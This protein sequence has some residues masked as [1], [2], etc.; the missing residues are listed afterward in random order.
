MILK[1]VDTYYTLLQGHATLEDVIPLELNLLTSVDV[2]MCLSYMLRYQLC[3][4]HNTS[5]RFLTVPVGRVFY[6]TSVPQTESKAV[7]KSNNLVPH[8]D[9]RPGKP[10]M[11]ELYRM[12]KKEFDKMDKNVDR[13][14]SLFD[15]QEKSGRTYWRDEIDKSVSSRTPASSSATTSRHGGRRRNRHEASQAYGGR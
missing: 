4:F 13:M 12:L 8:D 3:I 15:R 6:C 9:Y 1:K 14:T 5:Q 11:A 7:P 2:L 10:T